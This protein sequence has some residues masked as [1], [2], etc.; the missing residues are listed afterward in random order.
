VAIDFGHAFGS[1]TQFLPFPELVPFRLTRQLV[2][3]LS[4]HETGG[5]LEN[6]MVRVMTCKSPL[7]PHQKLDNNPF[8]V[9]LRFTGA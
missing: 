1:A 3:F 5:L 9:A 7:L 4:P 8:L 2:Q 6:T